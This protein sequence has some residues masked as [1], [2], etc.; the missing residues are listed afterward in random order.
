M[1][2][3]KC[4]NCQAS[5]EFIEWGFCTNCEAEVDLPLPPPVSHPWIVGGP[6]AKAPRDPQEQARRESDRFVE[7]LERIKAEN[8]GKLP[9]PGPRDITNDRIYTS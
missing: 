2:E 9:D 6:T 4:P 7:S 8:G 5:A 1:T 3:Q